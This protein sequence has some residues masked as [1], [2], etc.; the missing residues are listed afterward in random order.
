MYIQTL[1]DRTVTVTEA[2]QGWTIIR[3]ELPRQLTVS[4]FIVVLYYAQLNPTQFIDIIM[5]AVKLD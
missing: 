3:S 1:T 5:A 4:S 2:A